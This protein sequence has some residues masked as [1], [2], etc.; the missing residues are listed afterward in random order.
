MK[1]ITSF[2]IVSFRRT[3]QV[4]DLVNRVCRWAEAH[5]VS[6]VFHPLLAGAVPAGM[7]VAPDETALIAGSGAVVSIGGDGTFLSVAHL[8]L[9]CGKPIVGINA[10]GLGFLTDIGPENLEENLDK[11]LR[12]DYHT[13]DRMII[14]AVLVRGGVPLKTFHALNDFFINR[15]DRPKLASLSVWFG[16]DFINTFRSDG[17]ILAT[18]AGSTA[19]S[20]SAGG[21]ILEPTVRALLLTPICPHSLAERP[22]ILPADRPIRITIGQRNPDLLLSADGLESE[23]IQPGDEIIVSSDRK[24]AN[25]IHLTEGAFFGSLRT[26]LN[27][28]Q[29]HLR[30]RADSYDS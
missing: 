22:I 24:Q 15:F 29:D 2:G 12:G 9:F 1:P 7:S 10:G 25:L 5:P 16:P 3:P 13:I 4:A 18:P 6:L 20:L 8:C 27:W 17:L 14:K 26:K 11:I 21:P 30:N 19:Y 28:G 23:R